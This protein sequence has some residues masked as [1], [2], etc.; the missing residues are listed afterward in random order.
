MIFLIRE[1]GPAP[2]WS[3]AVVF[4]RTWS[5]ASKGLSD[6]RMLMKGLDRNGWHAAAIYYLVTSFLASGPMRMVLQKF[7]N[8]P[9]KAVIMAGAVPK[10]KGRQYH[11]KG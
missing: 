1:L 10:A 6:F 11:V 9:S 7:P 4:S 5:Q 8:T 2:C 3:A